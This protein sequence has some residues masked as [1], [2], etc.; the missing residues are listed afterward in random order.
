[1][2][3]IFP[4]R[5]EPAKREVPRNSAAYMY[6]G[7]GGIVIGSA[8]TAVMERSAPAQM[9]SSSTK[10]KAKTPAALADAELPDTAEYE[11]LCSE[12]GIAPTAIVANRVLH[13]FQSKRIPRYD[14]A[15]VSAYM[16]SITPK[17]LHWG[18]QRLGTIKSKAERDMAAVIERQNAIW[19][20]ARGVGIVMGSGSAVFGID[21]DFTRH[22][23]GGTINGK[24]KKLVPMHILKRMKVVK[25]LFSDEDPKFYVTDYAVPDPDPFIKVRLACGEEVIFGVW[26]EPGFGDLKTEV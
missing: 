4:G 15:E 14:A 18:W 19:Q 17:G 12:L 7:A 26:D 24:Y 16:A 23:N 6:D 21:D 2:S 11:A 8:D 5:S 9:S 25:E 22:M 10:A 13:T 20:S 3:F 1:M